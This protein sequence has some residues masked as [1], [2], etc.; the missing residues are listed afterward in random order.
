[1]Q[2]KQVL[3]R[4]TRKTVS[5]VLYSLSAVFFVGALTVAACGV[6]L[7]DWTVYAFVACTLSV[8]LAASLGGQA[9][10]RKPEQEPADVDDVQAEGKPADPSR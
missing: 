5:V 10:Q 7:P 1:V 6:E 4:I 2:R 8:A 9:P 3:H